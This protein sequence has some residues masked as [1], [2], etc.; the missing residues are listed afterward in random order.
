MFDL[1]EGDRDNASALGLHQYGLS[2]NAFESA[3]ESRATLHRRHGSDP[4]EM[5]LK[6]LIVEQRP[7]RPIETR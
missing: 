5:F 1:R 2:L 3:N 7:Q 4:H 6:T